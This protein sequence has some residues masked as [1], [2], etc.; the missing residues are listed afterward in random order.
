MG[1]G[2]TLIEFGL[3]GFIHTAEVYDVAYEG[4]VK[5]MKIKIINSK[6]ET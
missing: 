2:K 6:E 1:E 4:K 5:H 3:D